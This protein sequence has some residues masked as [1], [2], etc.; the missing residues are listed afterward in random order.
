MRWFGL[1][2]GREGSRPALSRGGM[3]TMAQGEWP[4]G[5]DA[6]VRAGY[7]G[8][9]VAQRAVRLVAEA[10]GSAPL[11]ASDP[12]LL[13]LVTARSGG[14]RLAEVVA[15]QVLLHGNAFVQV[16][17]DEAGKVAELYPLRPERVGVVLDAGGWAAGYRYTVGGRVSE[18][19]PDAVI[20]VRGFH[21][22]DDHYG[23]GCLGAAS[24]AIAVHNAAGRWNKALLDNAARPSGALVYDPGT[25]RRCQPSSSGDCARRW[26]QALP[27]WA[28]PGGQCC[29]RVGSSGRR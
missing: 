11:D 22:L 5:Y 4:S 17:R 23:L 1:K 29:W 9:A 27:V 2:A 21:P 3:A 28:M 7:L 18:I 16:L 12:A 15:A 19:A 24:G 25:D 10:V 8:N 6:Q 14:G 20:H 26:R 13:A